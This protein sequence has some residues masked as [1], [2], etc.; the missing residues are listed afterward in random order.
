[1][2]PTKEML[3]MCC[4][5]NADVLICLYFVCFSVFS[6]VAVCSALGVSFYSDSS[7]QNNIELENV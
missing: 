7:Q 6:W 5:M 4:Q 2:A 3:L 1:M